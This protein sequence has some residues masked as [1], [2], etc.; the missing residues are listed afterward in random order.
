M[1][2]VRF[3]TTF[4]GRLNRGR[5]WLSALLTRCGALALAM[6]LVPIILATAQN[7]GKVTL[8]VTPGDV[9]LLVDP[10]AMLRA[11][12]MLAT[13]DLTSPATLIPLLFRLILSPLAAWLFVVTSIKRLHDRDRSGWWLLLFFGVPHL[14][15]RFA[16]H[17]SD[18]Y[19]IA[20]FSL[21]AFA[22][23]IR[24]F[25]ELLFL[26][27]THKGN[28]FGPDPLLARPA[29]RPRPRRTDDRFKTPAPRAT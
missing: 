13:L 19:V 15:S 5:Y 7:S 21:V 22:L 20:A 12:E 3:L 4:E 27:G 9:L 17:M 6:L 11:F 25:V 16:D 8:Q 10:A 24:G 1:V 28:R 29:T 26:K 2:L 23:Y 14:Y 18:S